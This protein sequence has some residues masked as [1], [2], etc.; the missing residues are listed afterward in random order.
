MCIFS[1]YLKSVVFSLVFTK[2]SNG[3][4]NILAEEVLCVW[5]FIFFKKL[6]NRKKN[7]L[8]ILNTVILNTVS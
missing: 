3:N 1:F 2:C 8:I 4:I 5:D 7:R 6:Q